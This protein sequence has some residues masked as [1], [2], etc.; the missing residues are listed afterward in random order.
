M[1]YPT[2]KHCLQVFMPDIIL[3][4][5]LV[6]GLLC[7]LLLGMLLVKSRSTRRI[8][9]LD[10]RLQS[11]ESLNERLERTLRE[12]AEQSRS[13]SSRG[14][15]D[16]RDEVRRTLTD[17]NTTVTRTLSALGEAQGNRLDAFA[18]QLDLLTD[19][20]KQDAE[21]LRLGLSDSTTRMSTSAGEN[22]GKLTEELSRRLNDFS[23]RVDSLSKTQT[24]NSVAL[25][26]DLRDQLAAFGAASTQSFIALSKQVEQKLKDSA[27]HSGENLKAFS[28]QLGN[29]SQQHEVAAKNLRES[30]ESRLSSL[31][32]DNSQ[33]LELMRATVDEKL[34]GTLDRRLG[35]SFKQVSERLEQVQRGLGEMQSLGTNVTD[36]TRLMSNVKNRGTWGEWQLA[37]LLEQMLAPDQYCTN[38]R[39]SEESREVVEFAVRMPGR[40]QEDD[41]CWLPIDSKFPIEAFRRLSIAS[42][43]GDA[44]GVA[45]SE[46]ELE[47]AVLKCAADISSKYLNPP[48]TTGFAILFLPTES[49]FA[50]VLRRRGLM[51]VLQRDHRVT[52]TGPTTLAAILNSLQMGFRTLAIQKRTSQVEQV[53]GAVKTEFNKF[54]EMLEKVDKKL[55][56]AKSSVERATG[57]SRTIRRKLRDVDGLSAEESQ[58]LLPDSPLSEITEDD[59]DNT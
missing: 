44:S 29:L 15:A 8:D 56:E 5:I 47:T 58:S 32:N 55:D 16:L 48:R 4:V 45:T 40:G 6:I 41:V 11:L 33:K 46:A 57:K 26:A 13:A 30:V 25:K 21:R 10:A 1:H 20:T 39:P 43:A 51:E 12:E 19:N 42:E 35:E 14:A 7:L 54:G 36:L 34:Q 18:K 37:A 22:F 52:V 27:D 23:T 28:T 2:N 17:L 24:E 31:Q 50:E 9:A 49:L 53:L 38:F 59:G 3:V